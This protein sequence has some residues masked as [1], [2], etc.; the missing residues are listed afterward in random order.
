MQLEASAASIRKA[1]AFSA[2]ELGVD[3]YCHV[4]F[5]TLILF[6]ACFE[7]PLNHCALQE[8][9]ELAGK[10]EVRKHYFGDIYRTGLMLG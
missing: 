3:L 2:R 10:Q 7:H 5:C 4:K 1:D 9:Q 6:I 8:H